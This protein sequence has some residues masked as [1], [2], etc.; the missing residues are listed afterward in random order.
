MMQDQL[1][2]LITLMQAMHTQARQDMWDKVAEMDVKRQH[3]L[4]SFDTE[5]TSSLPASLLTA[6]VQLIRQI[7]RDI[8]QLAIEAKQKSATEHSNLQTQ[9]SQCE[10][11]RLAQS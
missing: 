4:K 11:Y 7:D 9:R 10:T 6:Q 1:E 8:L 5:T 3:L 2:E